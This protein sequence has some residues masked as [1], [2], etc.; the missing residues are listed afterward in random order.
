[1]KPGKK[2]VLGCLLGFVVWMTGCSGKNADLQQKENVVSESNSKE[3]WEVA[4]TTPY[5]KY[6]ELVEYTLG[7]MSGE[8]HSNLPE[9]DT[10]EDSAYTRYLRK[11]LNI[12]NKNIYME[13]ESIYNEFLN[14]IVKER[15]LPDI[16]VISDRERLEELVKKDLVEDL[17]EV[18]E[19][20][21][22]DR[23]KEMYNSYGDELLKTGMFDG[24]LMALPETVI[25][26]GPCFLWLR[27]DWMEQL[28]LKEPKSWEEAIEI[29]KVFQE[30]K[31][32]A[33]GQEDPV[34]LVC[35]IDLVGTTSS[36]YSADPI[37]DRYGAH[38]QKWI[39]RDGEIIYGSLTEETKQALDYLRELFQIGILDKNFV[40][41][42]Q[43][44]LRDLIIEGKCGAFFGLWWSPNNPLMNAYSS[45]E[46]SDWE[47]YYFP[48]EKEDDVIVYDNF[49]DNKYVVVRKGYEHPEILMK[50]INVLFDYTRYDAEDTEELDEYFAIN[51]DPTARPLVINV[52]YNEAT[53]KVTE[54]IQKALNGELSSEKLSAIERPYYDACKEYLAQKENAEE[55]AWAAYK[56]RISAISLLLKAKYEAKERNYLKGETIDIPQ[57]LKRLEKNAFIEIIMGRKPIDYFDTFVQEWYAQGGKELTEKMNGKGGE[58]K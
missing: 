6:P 35:D 11:M 14:V 10:Y 32:G 36:N 41:R 26:H 45:V 58:G 33:T 5:G 52:D 28:G 21:A 55:E 40:L 56:S 54:N 1:M 39:N 20:C 7:Q 51:V 53:Y 18:Y 30:N 24:K 23:I 38:P 34:G 29:I 3:L 44:N 25:D 49:R 9:G 27:K 22:S 50:I 19:L 2:L 8:N 17:T 15:E 46:G 42:A 13:N 47:P 37:F 12:Q 16:L 57:N 31:M 43:N 48:I 4:A